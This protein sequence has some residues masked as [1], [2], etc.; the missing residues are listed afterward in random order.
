M[1]LFFY[2]FTLIIIFPFLVVMMI[3]RIIYGKENKKRYLEKLGYASI[4]NFKSKSVIWFHACSVGEVKSIAN[5]ANSLLEKK[6]YILITTS[7]LL[8]SV[9]VKKFFSSKVKH[10]FLPVD[11]N[12]STLRFLNYWNPDI[13][14]FVESEIWPNLINN[15]KK[16]KIPL[17]LLQA[18]FSENTLRKW[19]YV[20]SYF[21]ETLSYFSLIIAQSEKDKKKLNKFA[22]IKVDDIYNLKNSSQALDVKKNELSKIKKNLEKYF[23]ITALSTHAGE[24]KIILNSL[25]KLANKISKIILIMQPRH[26][27]RSEKIKKVI[28]N[29]GFEYKQRSMKEYP[30]KQTDVYLADTFGESGTLISAADIIILG[31][32]L[33]PVGGHNVIE[34]AMFSKCIIVGK[35][36]SK[37]YDTIKIFKKHDAVKQIDKNSELSN[38]IYHLYNDK[39]M[40]KQIGRK[41]YSVT[42]D[43]PNQEKSIM[44][45][46]T[47]LVKNEDSKILV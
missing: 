24:E 9:Y 40:I 44:Y 2:N 21:K 45:Q 25:K 41:A 12:F 16:K 36:C 31:G 33:T 32:T 11:F 6:Y 3:F 8:S 28:N 47:S 43:F 42:N 10:Q 4:E 27:E 17:V 35:Y 38:M 18:S 19:S 34:P 20:K 15:C 29:I 13:G 1:F 7:T 22:N 46:I 23:F 5:L 14:I 37:I 30:N 26:P 39:K